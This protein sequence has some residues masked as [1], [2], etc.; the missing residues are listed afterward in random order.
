MRHAIAA[1]A[2]ALTLVPRPVSARD[3]L[4]SALDTYVRPLQELDVFGGAVLIS[5]GDKVL[6]RRSYGF[7]NQELAIP[8]SADKRFRIASI[9][10]FFTSA[11]I[12]CLIEDGALTFGTP[13]GRFLP[14]FPKADSITIEMLLRHRAG[15]PNVNELP[16][17][18]DSPIS[19]SLDDLIAHL[20]RQPLAFAPG[21]Q[22]RYSNGGYAILAKVIEKASGRSYEEF[23]TA[24][25]LS[26]LGLN[27]TGHEGDPFLLTNRAYGY[28]PDPRR[29]GRVVPAP[30]QQMA[31]KTGGGSL[32][33]TVHDLYLIARAW[34]RDNILRP[35]TWEAVWPSEEGVV[36]AQGRCP[37]YNSLLFRN[38]KNDVIVIILSNNY[39]SGML[40]KMGQDLESMALGRKVPSLP[41]HRGT[42]AEDADLTRFAG[43]YRIPDGALSFLEDRELDIRLEADHLVLWSGRTPVDVLVA[44]SGTT[45][46]AR[47]LWSELAFDRDGAHLTYRLLYRPQ[48]FTLPRSGT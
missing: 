28:A 42:V 8:N 40:A 31:T 41:Y 1:L 22:T 12:G 5:R 11:A 9:S 35:A 15:I 23:L 36:S 21:T 10:K 16:I 30:Y 47:N 29:P 7:A 25:V 33:S 43:H 46:L 13:L 17:L 48:E 4:G 27:D 20:A 45:F 37:G 19:N 14:E 39:A 24:R 32:Y 2:L 26:P 18:E 3:D 6:A 44:Q 38:L 34:G